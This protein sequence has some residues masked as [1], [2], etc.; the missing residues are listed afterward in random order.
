MIEIPLRAGDT[1]THQRFS[2]RL[3]DNLLEFRINYL[4]Y[5]ESPAWSMDILRD[6][7]YLVAGAMLE[8]NAEVTRG[9][10]AKIGRFFFIGDNVTLDNLGINNKLVWTAA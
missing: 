6:G 10:R 9:Y 4:S 3:E 5:L 2:L 7:T 1:N 8:P